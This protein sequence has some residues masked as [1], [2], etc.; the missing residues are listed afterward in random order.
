MRMRGGEATGPW[1]ARHG[2]LVYLIMA[3]LGIKR[4]NHAAKNPH[5]IGQLD[6]PAFLWYLAL[7]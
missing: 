7:A 6:S 4:A 1:D 3:P 2:L 5:Q